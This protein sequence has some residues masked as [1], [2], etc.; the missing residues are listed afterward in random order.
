MVSDGAFYA[1]VRPAAAVCLWY[2]TINLRAL[3]SSSCT[4]EPS[5]VG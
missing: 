4:Q 3:R 5:D 2:S 1:F